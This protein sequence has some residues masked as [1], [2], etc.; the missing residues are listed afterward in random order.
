MVLQ[1]PKNF[2]DRKLFHEKTPVVNANL[3]PHLVQTQHKVEFLSHMIGILL[4]YLFYDKARQ[5]QIYDKDFMGNK[6]ID[7]CGILLAQQIR[8][9]LYRMRGFVGFVNTETSVFTISRTKSGQGHD[10]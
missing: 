9:A 2:S 7:V 4:N 6:R 3:L 8:N 5:S 1:R 10:L